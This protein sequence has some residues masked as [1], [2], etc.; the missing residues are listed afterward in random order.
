MGTTVHHKYIAGVS[1]FL[2][3]IASILAAEGA[4]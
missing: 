2:I 3:I 1:G 4:G